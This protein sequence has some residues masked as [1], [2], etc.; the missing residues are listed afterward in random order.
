MEEYTVKLPYVDEH[1]QDEGFVKEILDISNK[2]DNDARPV[3]ITKN[4][5]EAFTIVKKAREVCGR[6][7][8]E[9]ESNVFVVS[10]DV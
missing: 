1:E 8:C 3:F 4:Q 6:Y 7:S 10:S 2:I 5:S 9:D